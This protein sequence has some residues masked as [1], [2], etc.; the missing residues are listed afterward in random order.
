MELEG[1]KRG[2]QHLENAGLHVENLVT[3]RHGMVKRFM[4][5]EHE[6]KNHFLDVCHVAK[7]NYTPLLYLCSVYD[8]MIQLSKQT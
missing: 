5:E 3:D 2:L 1:L 8:D 6:D 4:R 7:G